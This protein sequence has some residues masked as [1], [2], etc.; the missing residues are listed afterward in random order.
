MEHRCVGGLGAVLTAEQP[1]RQLGVVDH[2]GDD[3][4]WPTQAIPV[5]PGPL[6]AGLSGQVPIWPAQRGAERLGRRRSRDFGR[7]EVVV[8][9]VVAVSRR[10]L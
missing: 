10:G 2:G 6:D 9:N 7:A 1:V 4:F 3:E 8:V 5:G